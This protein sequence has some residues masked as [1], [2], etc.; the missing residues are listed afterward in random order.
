MIRRFHFLVFHLLFLSGASSLFAAGAEP[1]PLWQYLSVRWAR[2]PEFSP[3]GQELLFLT[4]ITGVPQIWATHSAGGWPEQITFDTNGVSYAA[5]SP[6]DRNRVLVAADRGGNERDQLY[7]V[8]PRGGP[9]EKLTKNDNAIYQFG[10]WTRDGRKIAY[11]SNE[12]DA[13]VFDIYVLDVATKQAK[14]IHEGDGNWA[15]S[16]W[17]P[18]GRY[19][20]LLK[21]HSSFNSDLYIYDSLT[22][23]VKLMTAHEGDAVFSGPQWFPDSKNF[24]LTSDWDRQFVGL[25]AMDVDSGSLAWIDTTDWDMETEALSRDGLKRAWTVNVDGYSE[26]HLLDMLTGMQVKPYR[27]PKGVVRDLKFSPDSKSL[28]ITFGSGK[29]PDDIYIYNSVNDQL[30]PITQSAC[31]GIRPETFVKPELVHYTTFDNRQI[32]AFLYKS[33]ASKGKMPVIVYAHGG[34][35]SQARPNFSGLFQYFVSRG[36][37]VFEPNIRGSTGYGKDYEQLDNIDGRMN[38][39]KDV[40]Y[41]ARWLASQSDVDT[42]RL[43][44]YGGSYGGFLVLA[45]LVTYPERWAAG[46]DI[47]GISNFISF[48]QNTGQWRRTHREAEYG[49]LDKDTVLLKEISPLTHVDKI[50][51][52][53]FIVQG[54]N[55]PRVPKSEADQIY[56]AVKARGIPVEYIVF[57]DEGHGIDKLPNRIHAYTRMVEFLDEHVMKK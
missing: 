41:G 4:N 49:S 15:A 26:F 31:G 40:E 3:N 17:S 21:N 53:L 20:G 16:N 52:P 50:R 36:Y 48:L 45:S 38:A 34:P 14:M 25:A 13:S 9:W 42:N 46:V 7:F 8:D 43:I 37:A 57:P 5:W 18:D 35:E 28:A 33:P 44:I 27:L 23:G 39:V 11:A 22:T 30:S 32:P 29:E 51:A 6:T 2:S 24:Y 19:L 1:L 54:A 55:D 10:D 12:R 47:V 56:E